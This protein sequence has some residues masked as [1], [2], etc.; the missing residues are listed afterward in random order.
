MNETKRYLGQPDNEIWFYDKEMPYYELTNFFYNQESRSGSGVVGS[1]QYPIKSKLPINY[2]PHFSDKNSRKRIL[3]ARGRIPEQHKNFYYEDFFRFLDTTLAGLQVY[4]KEK[5][6]WLEINKVEGQGKE[7]TWFT[8][9]HLFQALKFTDW[10]GNNLMEAVGGGEDMCGRYI[11][12]SLLAETIEEIAR[13]TNPRR[14]RDELGQRK[15]NSNG[16]IRR[17]WVKIM[18]LHIYHKWGCPGLYHPLRKDL[19]LECEYTPMRL[20]AMRYIVREKFTQHEDLRKLLYKTGD[21]KLVE[22]TTSD[23]FWGDGG[24]GSGQNWL[25]KILMEIRQ[26]IIQEKGKVYEGPE[27]TPGIPESTEPEKTEEETTL[28]SEE[29]TNPEKDQK[30]NPESDTPTIPTPPTSDETTRLKNE[31]QEKKDSEDPEEIFN[32]LKENYKKVVDSPD[33]DLWNDERAAEDK[34]KELDK[35]K[36]RQVIKDQVD[37]VL[38]QNGLTSV[39]L[40]ETKS[41]YT[42]LSNNNNNNDQT[43]RDEILAET[44]KLA[45]AKII[46]ALEQALAAKNKNE[47]RK[48]EQELARFAQNGVGY[49]KQ[50]VSLEQTKITQLSQQAQDLLNKND[51][52]NEGPPNPS[53]FSLDNPWLWI[54]GLAVVGVIVAVGI[55]IRRKMRIKRS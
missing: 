12:R 15:W 7:F 31:F 53:F 33:E 16:I 3:D 37:Y 54:S 32:S 5:M 55:V 50:A 8:A 20:R 49:R 47:V 10:S 23:N 29:L 46:T 39:D 11:K 17:D 22:H 24:D 4:W 34:L 40:K 52:N 43:T 36:L 51:D 19:E 25:G 35:D 44:G 45:L 42:E 27:E 2:F 1:A 13:E 48:K 38:E 18:G 28:T 41:K 9:E 6:N 14:V 30:K 21:K 26:E